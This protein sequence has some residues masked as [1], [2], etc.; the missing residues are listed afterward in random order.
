MNRTKNLEIY[1]SRNGVIG[2]FILEKSE[3]ILAIENTNNKKFKEDIETIIILDISGSM[4]NEVARITSNIL[5]FVFK[6]LKYDDNEN[7]LMIMF[8]SQAH[9]QNDS[10]KNIFSK[11]Y[12]S[13]GGTAF[14]PALLKLEKHLDKLQKRNIRILTI[15]DGDI[16]DQDSSVDHS[17]II[18]TKIKGKF[19]INSQAVRFF[20]SADQPDTRA[21]SSILQFSTNHICN[22]TDISKNLNDTEII[23]KISLLF[24]NDKFGFPKKLTSNISIL[25]EGPWSDPISSIYLDFGENIFWIEKIP[26]KNS[27][28]L[29]I[30]E[31]KIIVEFITKDLNKN[32]YFKLIKIKNGFYEQKIKILNIINTIHS[33]KEVKMIVDYF[34][35]FEN[36]LIS[37]DDL[38]NDSPNDESVLK[39]LKK[40]AL[41]LKKLIDKR[42]KPPS[43][44]LSELANYNNVDKL[45]SNQQKEYLTNFNVD[46]NSIGLAKRPLNTGIDFD[47]IARAE[48]KKMHENIQEL[49][50]ID[51]TNHTKSFYSSSTTLEGIKMTC[52]L[53]DDNV[54]DDF[55]CNDL[56]KMLNI[57]GIACDS[58]IGNFV[59]PMTWKVNKIYPGC[60]TSLSDVF[61]VEEISHLKHLNDFS[62][63]QDIQNVIPFYEDIKIHKFLKNY[64]PNLLEYSASVGMR[65]NLANIPQSYNYTLVSGC[66]KMIETLDKNKSILNMNTFISLVKTYE[67]SIGNYFFSILENIKE[68]DKK[69]SY[70]IASNGITNMFSPLIYLIKQKKTQF[71]DR[72]LRAIYAHETYLLAIELLKD[73]ENPNSSASNKLFSLL[74]FD[75]EKYGTK[76]PEMFT[77]DENKKFMNE[78]FINKEMLDNFIKSIWYLDYITLI[79]PYLEA[80]FSENPLKN[81][82][83]IPQMTEENILVSLNLNKFKS[84]DSCSNSSD[85]SIDIIKKDSEELSNYS[86]RKFKFYNFVQG[87]LY[88]SKATRADDRNKKMLIKDLKYNFRFEKKIRQSTKNFYRDNF[89]INLEKQKKKEYEILCELLLND[90]MKSDI[91]TFKKLIINGVKKGCRSIFINNSEKFLYVELVNKITD[92]NQNC[93]Q[94]IKKIEILLRGVDKNSYDSIDLFNYQNAIQRDH[95]KFFKEIYFNLTDENLHKMIL[96]SK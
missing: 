60:Y 13:R 39:D 28:H 70:Y 65:R 58:P 32:N 80:V 16:S 72:I 8:E 51:D 84:N 67:F 94:R 5:P 44:I 26:E 62:T 48:V 77:E 81:L 66:L 38:V 86:L 12:T 53:V 9:A 93:N 79:P 27:I 41:F 54:I 92:I 11:T 31:S 88:N 55:T 64:A 22:L 17:S 46:K 59:D 90:L 82:K 15:S 85:D 52:K 20:T 37:Q 75:L 63:K 71:N 6:K 78:Y 50:G 35:N 3:V 95:L 89:L 69:T 19:N 29:E 74:G 33:L 42:I 73:E 14:Y 23:D 87:L 56:L 25:N 7:I 34:I 10:I 45:N 68:Q 96:N 1:A 36:S 47:D 30:G 24:Q 61:L 2:K 40:R 76:L 21:L 83:L 49:N 91:E 43:K 57:V 4:G 18:A